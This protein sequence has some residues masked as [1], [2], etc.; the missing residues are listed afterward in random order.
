MV[1]FCGAHLIR[2]LA[3]LR[4]FLPSC[5]E[6]DNHREGIALPCENPEGNH[7]K[8]ILMTTLYSQERYSHEEVIEE[9]KPFLFSADASSSQ[10][11]CQKACYLVVS[12]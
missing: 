8:R 5:T 6:K 10:H 9:I 4:S 12:T 1:A 2:E 11:R 3:Y 7:V